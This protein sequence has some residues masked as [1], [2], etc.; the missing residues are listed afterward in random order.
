MFLQGEVRKFTLGCFGNLSCRTAFKLSVE[1]LS[2]ESFVAPNLFRK[3]FSGEV[4]DIS[5]DLYLKEGLKFD[6]LFINLE[7]T[8]T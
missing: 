5:L 6:D 4:I 8:N 7:S 2:T 3:L 1:S